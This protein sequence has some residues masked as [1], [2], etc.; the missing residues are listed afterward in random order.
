MEPAAGLKS[1]NLNSALDAW[2]LDRAA[3][4]AFRGGNAQIHDPAFRAQQSEFLLAGPAET[5]K[6]ISG[7]SLIDWIA[8]HCPGAQMT[9]VRKW[10]AD[11][12]GTVLQ[13][14]RDKILGP[15]SQVRVFGGNHPEWYDYPTG[16]R[17]WIGG[18][19]HPGK[20]LSSERDA[21]YVNQAEELAVEDWETLST[22]TTGRAGVL[23]PGLLFG[24]CNPLGVQHWI[25]ARARAG[26]LTLLPTYHKDNPVLFDDAGQPTPQGQRTLKRLESL[27]GVRRKRLFEGLWTTPE[28]V[29]FDEF[30][31]DV[32]VQT[33]KP[34][35]FQYWF[36]ALDEGYVHPAVILL[37]GVDADLRLHVAREFYRRGVLN[38][39]VAKR[40]VQWATQ[41]RTRLVVV[42]QA[43]AGLIAEIQSLDDALEVVGSKGRVQDGIGLVQEL[44]KVQGDGRPR[45]TIDPSCVNTI[46]DFES[47]VHKPGSEAVVKANDDTCDALR[48]GVFY[49]FGSEVEE[50]S[51]VDPHVDIGPDY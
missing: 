12:N 2:A 6:T 40:A 27:T 32:H 49:L 23:Q 13:T 22:R 37:V 42:D 31:R 20:A 47:Y 29:V 8:W 17:V 39:A 21:V 18:I 5:G 28:G 24:D 35:E 11:M 7:L 43:A 34:S 1:P 4:Y 48:Y 51:L 45:L 26:A 9:I 33:R 15:H 36:L 50:Q 16:S 3:G 19:D 25:L 38:S 14:F 46:N 44:L 30:N 41:A 10:Q